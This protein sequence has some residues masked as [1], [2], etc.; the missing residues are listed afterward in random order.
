LLGLNEPGSEIPKLRGPKRAT[1]I[2]KE[3]GL[4]EIYNKKKKDQKERKTLPLMITRL[5]PKREVKT[6]NGKTYHK[7]PK[8]QRLITPQRLQRKK[9]IKAIKKERR[10]YA[11]KQKQAYDETLKNFKRNKKNEKKQRRKHK[12]AAA[13]KK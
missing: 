4:L 2:L 3:F 8:V 7:R 12:A 1:K 9:V 5:L 10:E 6:K 13:E 11:T